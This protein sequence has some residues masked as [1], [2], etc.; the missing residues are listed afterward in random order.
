MEVLRKGQKILEHNNIPVAR[1][2]A[3]VLMARVLKC[4]RHD[5][6]L[7]KDWK[8][9][10][11]QAQ[12]FFALIDRRRCGCPIQYIINRQ[13]FMGLEFYVDHRVLIPRPDTEILVEHVIEWA[14]QINRDIRILDVGTGSGAIAVSLAV[15]L[16][17]AY[18][19]AVDISPEALEV[20]EHNA[21]I[22][23]V[24]ERI[25]ILKGDLFSPLSNNPEMQPFDVLVSNP[26][27][28]PTQHIEGLHSQVRNYEPHVALDG[29]YDGLKFY[30]RLLNEGLY[31]LK[32]GGLLAVEVGY[33]QY[34]AVKTMLENTGHHVN[35]VVKKDL[36]GIERVVSAIRSCGF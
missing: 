25:T 34:Q 21:R 16:P 23:G 35:I 15:F 19:T 28:I 26:P 1:L 5:L 24:Q 22:H 4:R 20:A 18:V 13:E 3:E 30:R 31:W 29:G 32:P 6:Y 2:E 27:Y 12:E 14:S 11:E 17:R 36:A 9:D 7:V 8:L 10:C 33:G